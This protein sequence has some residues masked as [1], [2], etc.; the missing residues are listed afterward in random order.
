LKGTIFDIKRFAVHDGS[1][2]RTAVFLKG[3]PL[4]CT[5]CHNPEG[6]DGSISLRYFEKQCIRCRSCLQS[7]P[8][9]ALSSSENDGGFRIHVDHSICT[10]CG[11]CVEICPSNALCFDGRV[12]DS[13]DVLMEIMRDE[14]FYLTSG[15]GI[16]LTGGDPLDQPEFSMEILKRCGDLGIHRTIETAL[17][18]SRNVI[19]SIVP[20]VDFFIVDLKIFD[21]GEHQK[22]TGVRNAVIFENFRLLVSLIRDTSLPLVRIP[23]I[24]HVTATESNIKA[25]AQFVASVNPEIR[26][27]LL[28]YNPL[29]RSK[30]RTL[31][32]EFL[33]P[34][35]TKPFSFETMDSFKAML[36]ESG[37]VPFGE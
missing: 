37:I 8:V 26:I 25:I 4:N 2:I 22:Y 27:E 14:D 32:K 24:P 1:G 19:K 16:T 6:I 3:C 21:D 12:V 7:C 36:R 30:Y 35:D 23:L 10:R 17:F 20:L 28:N 9:N 5:W 34:D 15:G 31:G 11:E 18:T 33:I 29:A 13:S